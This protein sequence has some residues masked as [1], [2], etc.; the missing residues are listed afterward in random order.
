MKKIVI[1]D[2]SKDINFLI[3]DSL[4]FH[5]SYGQAKLHNCKILN[6][7]FFSQTKFEKFSKKINNTLFNFYNYLI[8]NKSKNEILTL[9][10]FNI[11][12]DKN[13]FYNKMYYLFELIKFI[14]TKKIKHIEIITDDDDFYYTYKSIK[15]KNLIVHNFCKRKNLSFLNYFLKIIFFHI[16]S[17][18]VI[19]FSK[20]YKP[21]NSIKTKLNEAC[22]SIFPLFYKKE[23]HFFYN[24]DYL[25]FN[26]LLTDE[27][28]LGNSLIK[29]IITLKKL[30][31]IENLISVESFVDIKSLIAN[32]F[33]SIDNYKLIKKAFSNKFEIN[34]INF[35][36]QFFFLFFNSLINFNKLNIYDSALD[37]LKKKI[38]INKFHYYLFEYNF[39]YFLNRLIR[40][41]SKNIELI[42][43]QHGI[44]SERIM[45]QNLSKKIDF[46]S[47]FPDKIICKY[48]F[49]YISYKKNFKNSFIKLKKNNQKTIPKTFNKKKGGGYD[50]FLGLHDCYNMVNELRNLKTDKN[51]Q[52]YLHPKIKY[53]NIL[54]LSKNLIFRHQTSNNKRKKILSSTS[55]I[56][57]QLYL[58]EKFYIMKPNNIIPLNPKVLDKYFFDMKNK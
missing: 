5:L 7:N 41:K 31:K 49:S 22:L 11:R 10:L 28:H 19:I 50:V 52:I 42:G 16:K 34:N 9:E 14:K 53:R 35:S 55:T 24:K 13:Q 32:L 20:L 18:I 33:K 23:K 39:G 21:Q 25:K 43:Y 36:K 8:K 46:K 38:K 54:D 29:N 47:F 27:T 17:L 45:W 6:K 30:R 56:P 37:N 12:N 44:Y 51:F 26:F 1:L 40:K 57:Y 58:K 4:V 15:I 3:K 2:L 48:N